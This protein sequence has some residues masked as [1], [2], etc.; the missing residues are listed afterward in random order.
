M[1]HNLALLLFKEMCNILWELSFE[2]PA[3]NMHTNCQKKKNLFLIPSSLYKQIQRTTFYKFVKRLLLFEGVIRDKIH[4]E[5][6]RNL[7]D[8]GG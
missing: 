4:L 3:F 8:P 6:P 2:E 7:A 1:L 5:M